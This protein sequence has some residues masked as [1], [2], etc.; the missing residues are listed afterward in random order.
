M[1]RHLHVQNA[2]LG[3]ARRA[4]VWAMSAPEL[5]PNELYGRPVVAI[6]MVCEG[7]QLS[8]R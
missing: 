2:S 7:R 8:E 6:A 3:S 5:S 1:R 4:S